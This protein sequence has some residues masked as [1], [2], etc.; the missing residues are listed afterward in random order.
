MADRTPEKVLSGGFPGAIHHPSNSY[1]GEWK[2]RSGDR[3]EAEERNWCGRVTS[4]PK[5]N[6]DKGERGGKEREIH[7]RGEHL[8][9]GICELRM[10]VWCVR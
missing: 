4:R 9:M 2:I 8:W 10:H 1:E 3:H 5:V 7:E 6:W